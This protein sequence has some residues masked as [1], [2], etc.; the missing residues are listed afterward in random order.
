MTHRMKKETLDIPEWALYY[1][2]Y[3][4]SDG[5]TEEEFDMLT[6]FIE[7]NFPM[8]YTM[9][10]QWDNYNEFDTHPAFGLPT[11][12]YQVDFYTP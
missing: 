7:F 4:E 3:N 12:T 8:G 2:A 5:L 10:V 11:K 6:A 9:E 1:L